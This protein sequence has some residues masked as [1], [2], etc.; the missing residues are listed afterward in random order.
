MIPAIILAMI[1]HRVSG[2]DDT[3]F[4]ALV[5]ILAIMAMSLCQLKVVTEVSLLFSSGFYFWK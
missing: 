1:V 3:L 5:I 2:D 4:L